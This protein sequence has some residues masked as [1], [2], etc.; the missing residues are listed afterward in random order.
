MME[1]MRQA[2]ANGEPEFHADNRS[3]E[4]PGFSARTVLWILTS[5]ACYYLA[6]RTAG[7]SFPT[8]VSLFFQHAILVSVLLL[9]PTRH[10]RAYTPA[11]ACTHFFA[12]QQ[13]HWPTLYAQQCEAF[14]AVKYVLR[15]RHSHVHRHCP[16]YHREAI[17]LS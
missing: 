17:T 2:I 9:V 13:E 16:S 3:A 4:Q 11:A 14:D 6:T 12:T 15:P 7:T 5:G 1:T 8:A 10:W